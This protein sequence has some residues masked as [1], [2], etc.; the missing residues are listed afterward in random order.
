MAVASLMLGRG[1]STG[2]PGKNLYKILGRTLMAYPLMAA[3][4]S[5]YVDGI[6]VSTDSYE[7]M[8]VGRRYGAEI[9]VRPPE[10]CTSRA[11]GEDAFVHGYRVIRD[12]LTAQG[13]TLHSWSYY[14]PMRQLF[15]AT[16]ST[17]ASRSFAQIP[18]STLRSRS[19]GTICG[20]R[21]GLESWTQRGVFGPSFRLKRLAIQRL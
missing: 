8:S 17:R 7:I 1:G 9:I 2:F 11:L 16:S 3:Q 4:A 15:P 18:C 10:L 13:K 20:A 19:L 21:C 5:R 6:Y 14:S 12:L